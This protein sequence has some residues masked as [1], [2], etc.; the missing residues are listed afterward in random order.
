MEQSKVG[1]HGGLLVG[2][3]AWFTTHCAINKDQPNR[4]AKAIYS[5]LQRVRESDTITRVLTE[6]QGRVWG[7]IMVEKKKGLRYAL[8]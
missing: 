4:K 6:N 1:N 3:P 5:D 2:S 8:V 7:R